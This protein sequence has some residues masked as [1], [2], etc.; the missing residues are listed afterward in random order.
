LGELLREGERLGLMLIPPRVLTPGALVDELLSL[1]APVA[2]PIESRLAWLEALRSSSDADLRSLLPQPPPRDGDPAPW[3]ELASRIASLHDEL[4]GE[5]RS[6][7]DV[8]DA[9]EAREM[10]GEGDRWRALASLHKRQRRLLGEAHL[11]DANDA[12]LAALSAKRSRGEAAD[13]DAPNTI[14]L[15]GVADLNAQQRL[16]LQAAD[17]EIV[18]LVHAPTEMADAFDDLGAVRVEAW[19][20]RC[21]D[22]ADEQII[23]ADKPVNQAQAALREI[24]RLA[25]AG[26]CRAVD[27]TLGVGD[28]ALLGDMVVAAQW[29]GLS[30]HRAGGEALTRSAPARLLLAMADFLDEPRFEHFATLLRHPDVERAVAR[31]A[32][33]EFA[34]EQWLRLLDEYLAEHLQGQADG[35]WLGDAHDQKRLKALWDLVQDVL[36]PLRN[37]ASGSAAAT[38]PL[39][40]WCQR[41]LDV[42]GN[43][44]AIEEPAPAADEDHDD[45]GAARALK[46]PPPDLRAIDACLELRNVIAEIAFAAPSLQPKMTAAQAVRIMLDHARSAALSEDRE[47][48]QIEALGWLEL[49]LDLAETLIVVGVNDGRVPESL[50]ADAFLPDTLRSHLGLM[51]NARRYARDAYLMQAMA[52]CRSTD[53]LRLIVGRRD[54]LNEPLTPSRLLLAC[55]EQTL[56]RRVL[57]FADDLSSRPTPPPIGLRSNESQTPGN[58]ASPTRSGF[59]VPRLQLPLEAPACMSVTDF[60][61]YMRCPYR[62]ALERVLWLKAFGDDCTELD[63]LTFGSLVHDTLSALIEEPGIASSEDPDLI[64]RFVSSRLHALVVQRHGA[65]PLPTILIQR[66]RIEQRLRA[67]A[68]FQAQAAREGWRI[69]HCEIDIDKTVSLDIPGDSAG[70]MPLRGKI[71]R[72]DEN[73]RTGRWRVIDYKTGERG[74]HPLESHHG[75]DNVPPIGP[76]LEWQD[77]QLPLYQYLATRAECLRLPTEAIE[78][79]YIVLPRRADSVAWLHAQWTP[80]HLEHG[81]ARARAIV[82][83][84]RAAVLTAEFSRNLEI[85]SVFDTYARICQTAAFRPSGEEGGEGESSASPG[86][87]E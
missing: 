48:G 62:W 65:R 20:N 1:A 47:P 78:L 70:P 45:E 85:D 60:G 3:M 10:F 19:S 73:I 38:S 58:E 39:H 49:H 43:V 13:D 63:P 79:G 5:M 50:T 9:A 32:D 76:D 64:F 54:A 11:E 83:E 80:A 22:I 52:R 35:S 36:Q 7:S 28:P 23:V 56:V 41:V 15:I 14:V 46:L 24:N 51:H 26:A 27:I 68:A 75:T 61:R 40:E 86:G 57:M 30:L 2:T 71:D 77:L 29:A 84:I 82:R 25:S 12:R 31:R 8:A 69:R 44:Y 34:R 74:D 16:A 42:L 66:A 55:D 81:I 53:N 18:A 59:V 4:A 87:D 17:V 21:L 72:I 6:F 67:F 37:T 33:H